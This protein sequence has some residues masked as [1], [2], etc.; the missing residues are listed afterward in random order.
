MG[1][2]NNDC[3]IDDTFVPVQ[4]SPSSV[5]GGLTTQDAPGRDNRPRSGRWTAS[6]SIGSAIDD[7]CPTVWKDGPG[8]GSVARLG[9]IM[10]TSSE[11]LMRRLARSTV[12]Q[13]CAEENAIEMK[14]PGEEQRRT[15]EVD[16]PRSGRS[17]WL[18]IPPSRDTHGI[19][20]EDEP[21]LEYISKEQAEKVSE[22]Q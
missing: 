18:Y 14:Y 1:Y 4:Y 8:Y 22:L 19:N 13:R 9:D 11:S 3:A 15:T 2:T 20:H 17:D 16:R 10:P 5:A 6:S 12:G 7:R 21:R